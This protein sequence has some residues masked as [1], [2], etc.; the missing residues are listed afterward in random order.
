MNIEG[1]S[2]E[3]GT[4]NQAKVTD[5]GQLST[6]AIT[7]TDSDFA[8][9]EG[10]A[11]TFYTGVLDVVGD[12]RQAVLYIKNDNE[13]AMFLERITLGTGES[14]DGLDSII[15]AEAVGNVMDSDP[16]VTAGIDKIP[17]NR[18]A[19]SPRDFIGVSKIGP[20]GPAVNGVIGN[21]SVGTFVEAEEFS[22]DSVV[23]KG[24]SIA[25]EVI[26]PAGNTLMR[27]TFNLRF[28]LL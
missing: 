5:E 24:N 7:L 1:T 8:T 27:M 16:I 15:V 23:P 4:I 25:I 2:P 14:A 19:G 3:S 6:K 26:P 20:T 17:L 10:R 22:L 9:I 12:T 18:N 13:T 28:Y 21:G 11:F